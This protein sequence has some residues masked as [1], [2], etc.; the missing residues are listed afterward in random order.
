[1]TTTI[2][3]TR[4]KHTSP[5]DESAAHDAAG[6][7]RTE[8]APRETPASQRAAARTAREGASS[9]PS[10]AS[11]RA[12]RDLAGALAASR[13]T[14]AS[15]HAAQSSMATAR[16]AIEQI[17]R[18]LPGHDVD[19]NA[20]ASRFGGSQFAAM[21]SSAVQAQAT[22]EFVQAALSRH[23][24]KAGAMIDL[25]LRGSSADRRELVKL[26]VASSGAHGLS[27]YAAAENALR[28]TARLDGQETREVVAMMRTGTSLHAALET[29]RREV[30]AADMR[31]SPMVSVDRQRNA[32][33]AAA[34]KQR[35]Q[36]ARLLQEVN[37]QYRRVPVLNRIAEAGVGIGASTGAVGSIT[38]DA[39][40]S[41]V[42]RDSAY[43]ER[44]VDKA[45]T[46]GGYVFGELTAKIE[47]AA[48]AYGRFVTAYD[49]YVQVNSQYQ[50]ALRRQDSAAIVSTSQRMS[51]LVPE[52]RAT[53]EA[54]G[55]QAEVIGRESKEFNGTAVHTAIHMY[56]SALS[57]GIGGFPGEH[58]VAKTVEHAATPLVSRGA[59]EIM[60]EG[61]GAWY[62]A[63]GEAAV[64]KVVA[65]A[66]CEE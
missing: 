12:L 37:T 34:Q 23:P 39:I 31:L 47:E 3:A 9:A 13:A 24:E 27:R 30:A 56:V 25:R 66:V 52:L 11:E 33:I 43:L 48:H 16:T 50:E 38:V 49:E 14:P 18:E 28:Q 10:D 58:A 53:A 44:S 21:S 51:A 5:A 17:A 45:E 2:D 42:S 41:A 8:Q 59:A 57:L 55:A 19:V 46:A 54:L 4:H 65:G 60:G 35:D 22:F 7:S 1:M 62:S 40:H 32:A 20:L 29:Q 64:T 15:S 26:A 6:A 63:T 61:A 36:A